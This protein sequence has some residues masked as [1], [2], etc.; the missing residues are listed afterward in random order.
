MVRGTVMGNVGTDGVLM[1]TLSTMVAAFC[2]PMTELWCYIEGKRGIFSISISPDCT[3]DALKKRIHDEQHFC[4]KPH[5]SAY[6]HLGNG[7]A[8]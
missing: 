6:D 1:L 3:F 4:P 8:A 2:Y 5:F 7:R